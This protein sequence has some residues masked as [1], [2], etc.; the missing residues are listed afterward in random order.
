MSPA[1]RPISVW[2]MQAFALIGLLTLLIAE[3]LVITNGMPPT[4]ANGTWFLISNVIF[5]LVGVTY[6]GFTFYGLQKRKSY[7]R[8]LAVGLLV[9]MLLPML[10]RMLV[11]WGVLAPLNGPLPT[12]EPGSPA[13]A[14]GQQMGSLLVF[15]GI[16]L[17]FVRL[18]WGQRAKRFFAQEIS[19]EIV[20]PPAPPRF[21]EESRLTASD[22]SGSEQVG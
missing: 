19:P 20:F 5:F 22:A 2:V 3:F 7:G 18:I 17:L 13:Q 4:T 11:L 16:G 21:A 1:P 12:L 8:W 14:A 9:Y 15:V 10:R 6:L